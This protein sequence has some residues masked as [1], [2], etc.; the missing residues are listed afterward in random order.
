MNLPDECPECKTPGKA[1]K[2]YGAVVQEQ[3]WFCCDVCS[4]PVLLTRAGDIVRV[5]KR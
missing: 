5:G 3:Q 1:L 2:P 4:T